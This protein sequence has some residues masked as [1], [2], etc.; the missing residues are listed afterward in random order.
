MA[1][2]IGIYVGERSCIWQEMGKKSTIKG[3]FLM[4]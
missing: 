2:P 4:L 3:F 1:P